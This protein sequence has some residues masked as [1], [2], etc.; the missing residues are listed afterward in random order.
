MSYDLSCYKSKVSKTIEQDVA[1]YLNKNLQ[2]NISENPRQWN[3]ENPVTNVYFLINWNESNTEQEDIEMFD[4]FDEFSNL[5]FSFHINYLRPTFFGLEIFPIIEKIVEDL[6]I[7]FLNPQ[8]EINPEY[9]MQFERG[10]LMEQWIRQNDKLSASNFIKSNL[11]YYPLEKSNNIWKY[12][13]KRNEIQDLLG[14]D[15]FVTKYFFL[16]SK[17]DGQI[18]TASVWTKHIPIVIPTVDF[19]IVQKKYKKLFRT[20]EESGLV[21]YSKIMEE[22]KDFFKPFA[23]EIQGLKR[24]GFDDTEKCVN[25]FN[26]L[27]IWKPLSEFGEIISNDSFVNVK[28]Q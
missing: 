25:K 13:Y 20:V 23:N 5:N 16:K 27:K 9:P 17:S 3:Y 19:V 7:Y 14:D 10:Y 21:P 22:F 11:D 8:A 15:I 2:F 28:P 24:I 6:D 12:L 18:Y 1:D 26:G 4:N